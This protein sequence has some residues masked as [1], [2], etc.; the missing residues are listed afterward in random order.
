MKITEEYLYTLRIQL[1][2][3]LFPD[4]K[5]CHLVEGIA[6]SFS[7]KTHAALLTKVR[8]DGGAEAEFN[9]TILEEYLKGYGYK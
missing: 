2:K 7:F 6:R 9:H 4:V 1:R 5:N 3:T 8:S